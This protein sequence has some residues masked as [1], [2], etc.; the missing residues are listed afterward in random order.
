MPVRVTSSNPARRLERAR[1]DKAIE[2]LA[3]S[4]FEEAASAPIPCHVGYL[5]VSVIDASLHEDAL[6]VAIS[7]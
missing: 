2:L 3:S 7:S 1:K 5:R 6:T 4:F